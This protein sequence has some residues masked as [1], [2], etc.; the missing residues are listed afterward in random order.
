MESTTVEM[1]LRTK[2]LQ[3]KH[4]VEILQHGTEHQTSA[5][6][7][8]RAPKGCEHANAQMIFYWQLDARVPHAT[9]DTKPHPVIQGDAIIVT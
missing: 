9:S 6:F 3:V 1:L 7:H 4:Y 8:F 2:H 5:L